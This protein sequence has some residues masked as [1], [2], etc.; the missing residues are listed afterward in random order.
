MLKTRLKYYTAAKPI[1]S[2]MRVISMAVFFKSLL[3]F[4]YRH[5]FSNW[6]N[7]CPVEI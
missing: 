2:A 4:S 1:F 7:D 3:A 5:L 6:Q